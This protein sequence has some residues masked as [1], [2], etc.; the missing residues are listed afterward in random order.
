MKAPHHSAGDG[1]Q[2][3][4]FEEAGF[5]QRQAENRDCDKDE[6]QR[7]HGRRYAP[8]HISP[9]PALAAAPLVIACRTWNKPHAIAMSQNCTFKPPERSKVHRCTGSGR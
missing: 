4:S 7:G 1:L 8:T 3:V 6:R 5:R 9:M 2:S